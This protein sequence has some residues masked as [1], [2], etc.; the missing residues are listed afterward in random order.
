MISLT[1][2]R[3]GIGRLAREATPGQRATVALVPGQEQRG[4][5]GGGEGHETAVW[6]ADARHVYGARPLGALVPRLTRPAFRRRAPATAQVLADWPSIVGPA[7]AAVTTPRRLVSG[8]L[9]IACAGP[10]AMELQYLGGELIG[11]INA[12]LGS[13]GRQ[14]P[15]LRADDRH[16][17]SG[18]AADA[19][20]DRRRSA[21]RP[22]RQSPA[23]PEGELRTALAAL[24]R[25]VLAR[26][27]PR[28]RADRTSKTPDVEVTMPLSRRSTLYLAG[29]IAAVGLTGQAP[30]QATPAPAEDQRKT[31][32]FLGNADAKVTVMEFF[33]LTCTHC[34][35]FARETMPDIEKTLI[36]TGQGPLRVPRLPA[37]PGGADRR[38]GRPLPAARTLLPVRQRTVREPGPLGL[39]PRRQFAPTNS[40]SWRR[41]PA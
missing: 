31:P 7:I 18:A 8:T 40:G 14:R 22:R 34:A 39:R 23:L 24:A 9:T 35:A 32:R 12:H 10:I 41:W 3:Y 27:R 33:S 37:R 16:G 29:G 13:R 19:P 15:A 2:I 6:P 11:R 21:P 1:Q 30:A 25:A 36:D 4:R 28:R 20:P 38:H 17:G 5:S 26:A